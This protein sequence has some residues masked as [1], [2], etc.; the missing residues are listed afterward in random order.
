MGA[1]WMKSNAVPMLRY[2]VAWLCWDT[3]GAELEDEK[4]I[5]H[6]AKNAGIRDDRGDRKRE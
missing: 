6:P 1:L 5:P 4:Q 2:E 3:C